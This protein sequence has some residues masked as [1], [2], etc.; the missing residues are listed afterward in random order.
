MNSLIGIWLFTAIIYQGQ[1][2]PPPN[3]A[4]KLHF[5]FLSAT[6]NEV[7]YYRQNERGYCRRWATYRIENSY[8]Y[9]EVTEV[10]PDND[11]SCAGDTDMQKGNIS[12]TFFELKDEKFYLHLPLGDEGI[13]YIFTKEIS[14]AR[15][16]SSFAN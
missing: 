15:S 16:T 5:I 8:L 9:Q 4:L 12:K 3:P 11:A 7:H 6:Q 1:Q 2:T 14:A 10:D 13:Q